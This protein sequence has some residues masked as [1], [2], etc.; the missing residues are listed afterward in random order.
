MNKKNLKNRIKKLEL[1]T[2]KDEYFICID[3]IVYYEGMQY[4]KEEYLKL[5]PKL[6]DCKIIE[7]F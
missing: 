7:I 6:E 3:E 5:Y 1:K 4:K 2:N